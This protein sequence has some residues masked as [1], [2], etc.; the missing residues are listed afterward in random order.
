MWNLERSLSFF[1]SSHSSRGY[2]SFYEESYGPL[3]KTEI[4]C[5]WPQRS[6]GEL[7]AQIKTAAVSREEPIWT[8]LHSLD[9]TPEGLI[10]PER[11]VGVFFPR[12]WDALYSDGNRL[13]A[14]YG[15]VKKALEESHRCFARALPIHDQ[16]ESI[17]IGET[18]FD[19]LNQ[20]AA[21]T[22]EG[23]LDGKAG[24]EPGKNV[25]R[26]LGAATHSGS[27]DV[28]D[29]ITADIPR[30][31]F[32][33]GRPGTGKSTFLKKIRAAANA[34]GWNT[35]E[36]RC[37]FD[38]NSADMV[39]I[40]GLGICLFDSTAPHEHFPSR[41]GDE[42]LDIYKA[43]VTPGTDE[44]YQ[45]EISAISRRYKEQIRQ[46]TAALDQAWTVWNRIDAQRDDWDS[47]AI[48]KEKEQILH[49]ILK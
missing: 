34:A 25:L 15:L 1:I 45:E 36:Y 20:L 29:Q 21:E 44:R 46:A 42:I 22:A 37:A 17:Y 33:K 7:L 35:E 26:F 24:T 30:R 32:I 47:A 40:P 48:Q 27:M 11:S 10:L 39:V 19:R 12:P 16:W 31:I 2:I 28:I 5:N 38:P 13:T 4:L 43:A 18:D 8:V 14:S 49:R 41:E 3:Q 6:A 23:L 9:G